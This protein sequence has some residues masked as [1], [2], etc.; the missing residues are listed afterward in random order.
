MSE[1]VELF[2]GVTDQQAR[3]VLE[4]IARSMVSLENKRGDEGSFFVEMRAESNNCSL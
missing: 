4:Y 2:P 3:Q 1:F